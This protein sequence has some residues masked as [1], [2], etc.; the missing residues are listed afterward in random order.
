MGPPVTPLLAADIIIELNDHARQIVLIGRKNPPLGW[1][2]PGGFVDVGE[3]VEQAAAREAQEETGL[4]VH[5]KCLLGC[6]SAPGRDPRG[7]TAS[8]VY[9]A[10][11]DGL[12]EARDDA[13]MTQLVDPEQ[14]DLEL[15]F[16]HG[17]ILA[18]YCILRNTGYAPQWGRA[19]QKASAER[20]VARGAER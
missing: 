11:A 15:V 7:H 6:Y 10:H 17:K 19:F 12:P 1:A 20:V 18:D 13:A 9:V 5:L 14:I 8:L 3:T 4:I 2:L 16:D